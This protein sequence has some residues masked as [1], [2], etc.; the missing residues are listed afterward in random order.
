LDL[1]KI[2]VVAK[3]EI[4]QLTKENIESITKD[5]MSSNKDLFKVTALDIELKKIEYDAPFL[6]NHKEGTW[7]L[8]YEQNYQNLPIYGS[9]IGLIINNGNLVLIDSN[10]H[11]DI[12]LSTTPRISEKDALKS[13]KNIL[14]IK[15]DMEAEKFS[16]V[17]FPKE[18]ESNYEYHLSWMIE[19]PFTK[20][21]LAKWVSFVDA[22][23]GEVLYTY[24]I[25]VNDTLS[26]HVS[27][28]IYPEYPAQGQTEVSFYN[29]NV[30]LKVFLPNHFF[31][32]GRGHN[33]NNFMQTVDKIDLSGVSEASLTFSSKYFIEWWYDRVY[34]QIST[35]NTTWDT[36]ANYTGSKTFWSTESIDLSD[37]VGRQIYLR[38]KYST[39][40]S[41]SYDG[42]YLDNISVITNTGIKFSD[43]A[44]SGSGKWIFYGFNILQDYI[45]SNPTTTDK[46][47]YYEISKLSDNVNLYSG[48]EGPYVDVINMN[49]SDAYH[50]Y[51]TNVPASH[52]W[53]WVNYDHSYK[54]EESNVFYHV[55][56]IHDFFTRGDPFDITA[57]NFQMKAYVEAGGSCNAMAGYSE[58]YFL[59]PGYCESTSLGSGIIYHE[60]THTVVDHVYITPLPYS[61]Q[62]GAMNEG[63]ADYFGAS[64]LNNPA[65]GEGIWPSPIRYLNNSLRYPDD[66]KGEVHDD[67]R[68]ISGA[69]WNL[70]NKF[71]SDQVDSLI[72]R[73]MK[74]EPHSFSEFLNDILIIDDDNGDLSD[75]TPHLYEI[76][77][78]FYQK[79][80]IFSDYC[81]TPKT[82]VYPY[83]NDTDIVIPGD[84]VWVWS[85][86]SVP[87][88]D[89]INIKDMFVYVG[90]KHSII[91]NLLVKL[92][93]PDGTTV[94]LHNKTGQYENDIYTWYDNETAVDGPGN[95]KD[96]NGKSSKGLWILNVSYVTSITGYIDTWSLKFYQEPTIEE[97]ITLLERENIELR[98]RIE[99]LEN[100]SFWIDKVKDAICYIFN[101]LSLT[102]LF[103]TC[104][105]TTTTTPTTS[106]T[107]TSTIISTTTSTIIPTTTTTST[108]TTIPPEGT[109]I[110]QVSSEC[111]LYYGL[112]CPISGYSRCEVQL[113]SAPCLYCNCPVTATLQP[114]RNYRTSTGCPYSVLSAGCKMTGYV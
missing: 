64:I 99:S 28:M 7:Y 108:T 58:I 5:F 1:K 97:R 19:L 23:N 68:I 29:E 107:T 88:S 105:T 44:E 57:M 63:W 21:P 95:L 46:S 110:Y 22:Q 38:F 56:K 32:F 49:Q 55:N 82:E 101:Y 34:V 20:D 31:Y 62:T 87:D 71:G 14:K 61:G 100:K 59:G 25:I 52:D 60:Y 79:H 41:Y 12:S 37:Y 86:I 83:K 98:K 85:T 39:D 47:G 104:P 90:I 18:K 91:G 84:D 72:I 106:S 70:R 24:N 76:C 109:I 67:S 78:S 81:I 75:G 102:N 94:T 51:N 26:G 15:D 45:F 65:I 114:G 77:N 16:L 80:G 50:F 13:M 42:F 3:K 96:F 10:L 43:N 74:M 8:F 11:P 69:M 54:N 27:G 30:S 66:W 48:F 92:T 112:S 93:S 53:N 4:T 111:N 89:N 73:A 103:W 33:L 113:D 40:Y 35:D 2:P 17:V 36:I 6:S 9:Y